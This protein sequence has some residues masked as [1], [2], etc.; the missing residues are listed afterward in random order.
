MYSFHSYSKY[1]IHFVDV[2]FFSESL[3]KYTQQH[4]VAT[5]IKEE[6]SVGMLLVDAKKLKEV[7]IPS[8]LK[9]L[10][11]RIF[12]CLF[13]SCIY[14]DQFLFA[15]ETYDVVPCV[16]SMSLISCSIYSVTIQF[17][18]RCLDLCVKSIF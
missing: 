7:L 12:Y 1:S 14:F 6:R 16:C 11:V 18:E 5:G 2:S 4:T 8:P 3:A 9:C 15:N 17:N 10:R 13:L